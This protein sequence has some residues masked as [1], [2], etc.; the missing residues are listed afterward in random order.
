MGEAGVSPEARPLPK[1]ERRS[2]R[3]IGRDLREKLK[4]VEPHSRGSKMLSQGGSMMISK[5]DM[6]MPTPFLVP[7]VEVEVEVESS[8]VLRVGKTDKRPLTV[9]RGKSTEEMLTSWRRR[10]KTLR[11]RTLEV[12][13]R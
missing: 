7:E 9:Q 8:H 13:S 2:P 5:V 10:G 12:E 11:M 3:R 6:L 4:G 1:K